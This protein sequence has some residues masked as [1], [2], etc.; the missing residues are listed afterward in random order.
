M[1]TTLRLVRYTKSKVLKVAFMKINSERPDVFLKKEKNRYY[2]QQCQDYV[3][4]KL[5]V[6]REIKRMAQGLISSL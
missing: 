6:Q 4:E 2:V 1:V 3:L 5:R